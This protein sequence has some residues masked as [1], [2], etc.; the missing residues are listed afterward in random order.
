MTTILEAAAVSVRLRRLWLGEIARSTQ[1]AASDLADAVHDVQLS[2]VADT[3]VVSGAYDFGVGDPFDSELGE[4]L[5]QRVVRLSGGTVTTVEWSF[6]PDL[7]PVRR[8]QSSD[9]D[10]FTPGD[11]ALEEL[12]TMLVRLRDRLPPLGA[13][14]RE[15]LG[16]LRLVAASKHRLWFAAPSVAVRDSLAR[17]PGARGAL[18][19]AVQRVQRHDLA[20]YRVVVDGSHRAKGLLL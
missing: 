14:A 15:T 10:I 4:R 6:D 19:T 2:R 17:V 1:L 12:P 9:L 8:P 13:E 3:L 11:P 20:L 16:R 5:R 7:K 18:T